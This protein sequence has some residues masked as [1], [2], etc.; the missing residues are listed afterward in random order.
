[1]HVFMQVHLLQKW[2]KQ[3][4]NE[5]KAKN[6]GLLSLFAIHWEIGPNYLKSL[7]FTLSI[8]PGNENCP[9]PVTR[10]QS[11]PNEKYVVVLVDMDKRSG[12]ESLFLYHFMKWK[13]W[14]DELFCMYICKYQNQNYIHTHIHLSVI[15]L[16]FLRGNNYQVFFQ[17]AQLINV[18]NICLIPTISGLISQDLMAWKPKPSLMW[19][20]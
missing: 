2:M 18:S 20:F 17:V 13:Y 16:D 19:M 5:H 4:D 3:K 7:N 6:S 10:I 15:S 1:M 8:L 9:N 12:G 14:N 11:V